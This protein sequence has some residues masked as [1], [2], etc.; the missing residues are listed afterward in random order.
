MG[1]GLRGLS[2]KKGEGL[3]VGKEERLKVGKGGMNKGWEGLNVG[4]KGKG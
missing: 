1:E 2:V 3:R 4:E